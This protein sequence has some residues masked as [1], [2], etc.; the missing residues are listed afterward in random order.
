[1]SPTYVLLISLSERSKSEGNSPPG[2]GALDWANTRTPKRTTSAATP[3]R[4]LI[5]S[6]YRQLRRYRTLLHSTRASLP[7][8]PSWHDN[9]I[10]RLQ[11]DILGKV[12]AV[13]HLFVVKGDEGRGTTGVD[14]EYV[15]L[16][17]LGK[18]A[19]STR[20]GDNV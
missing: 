7:D 16:L 10:L 5:I 18:I 14:P 9:R 11:F 1:M 3:T 13:D 15:N 2:G 19:K 20:Q 17:E 4:V 8:D 6:G 12:A